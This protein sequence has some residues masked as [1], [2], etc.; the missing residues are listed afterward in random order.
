[1]GHTTYPY[2]PGTEDIT[3]TGNLTGGGT[4]STTFYNLLSATEETINFTNLRSATFR[5]TVSSAFDDIV[6][7]S[8]I[9]EPAS[10]FLSPSLFCSQPFIG[11]A[12][13][14]GRKSGVDISVPRSEQ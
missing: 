11:L 6:V 2:G 3:I 4:V 1:M 8:T 7:I 10:I 9:P 13:A 14:V 12:P 5:G